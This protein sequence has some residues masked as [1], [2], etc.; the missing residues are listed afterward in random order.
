M[1]SEEKAN[2]LFNYFRDMRFAKRA[3]LLPAQK[4]V[5][6]ETCKKVCDEIIEALPLMDTA[7]YFWKD[8]KK[9]I[10]KL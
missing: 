2:E 6:I 8:V 5:L 10:E 9:E 1:K 7:F 4:H 3:E